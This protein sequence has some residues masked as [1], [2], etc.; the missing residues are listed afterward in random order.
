MLQTQFQFN[1][2]AAFEFEGL[3]GLCSVWPLCVLQVAWHLALET[4]DA[5][6]WLQFER[7]SLVWSRAMQFTAGQVLRVA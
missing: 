7:P 3:R 1:V 4:R 6:P 2:Q 5:Q